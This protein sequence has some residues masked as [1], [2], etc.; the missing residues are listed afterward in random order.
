MLKKSEITANCG[1]YSVQ[2]L[3]KDDDTYFSSGETDGK[4]EIT[5]N[6]GEEKIVRLLEICENIE[7]GQQIESFSVYTLEG[8]KFEKAESHTVVGSKK[9]ILPKKPMVT[10]AVKIVIEET[11]GFANIKKLEIYCA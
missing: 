1:G 11:R 2:N 3:K 10:S 7:T 9:L 8:K 4:I 6:F 5:I